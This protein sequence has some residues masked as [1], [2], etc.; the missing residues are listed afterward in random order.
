MATSISNSIQDQFTAQDQLSAMNSLSAVSNVSTT[1][2]NSSTVSNVSTTESNSSTESANMATEEA[3]SNQV[4]GNVTTSSQTSDQTSFNSCGIL[5]HGYLMLPSSDPTDNRLQFVTVQD[6]LG[7]DMATMRNMFLTEAY[8]ENMRYIDRNPYGTAP[9]TLQQVLV[10]RPEL[11]SQYVIV[12]HEPYVEIYRNQCSQAVT[13]G[14]MPPNYYIMNCNPFA[15][16][17]LT[18]EY[19]NVLARPFIT[20]A[21]SIQDKTDGTESTGNVE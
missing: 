16:D 15:Y 21:S 12:S 20:V 14:N 10:R 2:S 13:T 19:S 17:R 3:S 1:V 8:A 6:L 9:L 18:G 11:Q 4:P 5:A 7:V